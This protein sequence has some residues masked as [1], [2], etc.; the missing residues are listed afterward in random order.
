MALF[1]T[2]RFIDTDRHG[3]KVPRVITKPWYVG[4]RAL[5]KDRQWELA[6]VDEV[7]ADGDEFNFIFR[8]IDNIP[9]L[10]KDGHYVNHGRWFG[11]HARFIA[12]NLLV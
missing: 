2:T 5:F 6:D 12:G 3:V 8:Q 7:Y 9:R 10:I 1:V 11:D 4:E